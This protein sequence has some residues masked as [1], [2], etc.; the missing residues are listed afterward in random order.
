MEIPTKERALE[1][2]KKEVDGDGKGK[3][4]IAHDVNKVAGNYRLT[5]KGD[6]LEGRTETHCT[7]QYGV[8]YCPI[9]GVL[10]TFSP[11]KGPLNMTFLDVAAGKTPKFVGE[12]EGPTDLG[13]SN[14]G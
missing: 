12:L 10:R 13:W 5:H 7:W 8:V 14:V 4:I 9:Q 1:I 2:L 3:V 6:G 11:N